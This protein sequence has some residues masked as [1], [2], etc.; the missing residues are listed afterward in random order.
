MI[1]PHLT[2]HDL[3]RVRIH[4]AYLRRIGRGSLADVIAELVARQ[5]QGGDP[6]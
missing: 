4:V 3:E 5:P 6:R 1:K 2:E